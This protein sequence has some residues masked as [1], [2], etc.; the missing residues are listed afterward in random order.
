MAPLVM[1]AP[2]GLS[3]K[4]APVLTRD[5]RAVGGATGWGGIDHASQVMTP[6]W[7]AW[8]RKWPGSELQA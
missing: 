3:G 7:L 4:Q 8:A 1:R 6:G 5:A 2:R